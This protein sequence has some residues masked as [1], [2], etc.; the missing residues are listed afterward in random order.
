MAVFTAVN[1]VAQ[2]PD[3]MLDQESARDQSPRPSY[4]LGHTVFTIV[5]L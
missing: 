5:T 4:N 2:R 1:H 3:V